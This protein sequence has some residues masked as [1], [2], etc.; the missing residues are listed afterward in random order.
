MPKT[1][2]LASTL[3]IAFSA[4]LI[5]ACASGQSTEDEE[6]GP[7]GGKRGAPPEALE[8]CANLEADA[9]CS[10]SGRRGNV[11]GQCKA[12]RGDAEGLVCVPEGGRPR[13]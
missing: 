7:R 10:F 4:T 13:R 8:A 5:A 1:N 11:S 9:A 6:R 12:M 2:R 3:L